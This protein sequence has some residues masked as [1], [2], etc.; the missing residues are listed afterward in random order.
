MRQGHNELTTLLF[1]QTHTAL[2]V[3]MRLFKNDIFPKSPSPKLPPEVMDLSGKVKGPFRMVFGVHLEIFQVSGTLNPC[4][5]HKFAGAWTVQAGQHVFKS[6]S[7]VF[8]NFFART[9]RRTFATKQ[10]S[11]SSADMTL[12]TS[13]CFMVLLPKSLLKGTWLATGSMNSDSSGYWCKPL[14]ACV[15]NKCFTL[16]RKA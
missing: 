8:T 4:I 15:P 2:S 11:V 10:N 3:L 13:F 14:Q 6:V 7:L 9:F 1:Q 5:S 12:K 16:K